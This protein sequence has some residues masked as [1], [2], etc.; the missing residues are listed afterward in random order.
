MN[1]LSCFGVYRPL[2]LLVIMKECTSYKVWHANVIVS[3]DSDADDN[4]DD[5]DVK[6][7]IVTHLSL[8]LISD[9]FSN[10]AIILTSRNYIKIK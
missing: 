10:I 5:N 1:E 7:C 9:G 4:D 2:A 6:I 8:I 3:I